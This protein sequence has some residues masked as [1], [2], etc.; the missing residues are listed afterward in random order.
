MSG[1]YNDQKHF[2]INLDA[3]KQFRN[4]YFCNLRSK[5]GRFCPFFTLQDPNLNK[6]TKMLGQQLKI[7]PK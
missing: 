1:P 2:K 5:N 7:V 6:I 3:L 4:H